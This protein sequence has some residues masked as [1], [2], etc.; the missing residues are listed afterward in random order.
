M[1][2][3]FAKNETDYINKYKK[4]GYTDSYRF[5]DGKLRST[6]GK[7]NYR[8][9]DIFIINEHR[10]EGMSNPSD[11]SLLYVLETS[12]GNK[13]T[14]LTGYGPSANI[15]LYEFIKSIPQ[16]N[17]RKENILPPDAVQ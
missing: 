15:E 9:T 5:I 10:Y 1:K 14:L 7:K 2:N 12:D 11:M 13:G 8:A 17:I 3:N 6:N 4:L 16:E